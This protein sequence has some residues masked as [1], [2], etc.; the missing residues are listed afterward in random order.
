VLALII[1]TIPNHPHIFRMALACWI[2]FTLNLGLHISWTMVFIDAISLTPL[3]VL[4]ACAKTHII[5]SSLVMPFLDFLF[6]LSVLCQLKIVK[7]TRQ[8][9][10]KT[11]KIWKTKLSLD[12]VWM[13]N[14]TKN[15]SFSFFLQ[16]KSSKSV[17]LKDN[18]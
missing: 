5:F 16:K 17:K 9:G 8:S 10:E 15:L 4:M 6:F 7:P 12:V 1:S 14:V 11:N 13:W 2:S 18:D 3:Y